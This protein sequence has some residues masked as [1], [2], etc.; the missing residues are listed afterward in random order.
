MNP[1]FPFGFLNFYPVRAE[2]WAYVDI[3]SFTQINP[4]INTEVL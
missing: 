3:I 4:M 1:L 2:K